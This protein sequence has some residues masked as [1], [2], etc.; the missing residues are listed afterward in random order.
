MSVYLGGSDTRRGKAPLE[1]WAVQCGE[2]R[3]SNFQE[4]TPGTG[5]QWWHQIAAACCPQGMG[6]EGP[7]RCTR[8][9][10][11]R[12]GICS[13]Q[14]LQTNRLCH[15]T[16][17]IYFLLKG[18]PPPCGQFF[19]MIFH[20]RTFLGIIFHFCPFFKFFKINE[21]FRQLHSAN[22]F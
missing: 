9:P 13:P 21:L 22:V 15:Q 18:L 10:G 8:N 11:G 14:A 1:R 3:G 5:Q 17:P 20:T 7:L 6:L 12:A 19:V 16:G 4:Y 2:G